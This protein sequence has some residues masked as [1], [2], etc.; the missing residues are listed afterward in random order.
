MVTTPPVAVSL[1]AGEMAAL[2]CTAT[3]KPPP[4]LSWHYGGHQ[5]ERDG[6]HSLL[7]NGTLL[8]YETESGHDG[9]VY[10]CRAQNSVGEAELRHLLFVL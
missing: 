3:G 8:V 1:R 4:T 2:Y 7:A 6:T 9:G 5:L 10:T